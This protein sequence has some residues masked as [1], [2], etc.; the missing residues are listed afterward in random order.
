MRLIA[1]WFGMVMCLVTSCEG[2]SSGDSRVDTAPNLAQASRNYILKCS[3]CHG[4]DGAPVLL[5]APDLRTSTLDLDEREAIIA[6]GK[7]TMPPHQ[8]MLSKAEIRDLALYIEE[9]R[10]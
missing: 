9:F 7:G 8:A 4:A 2:G 3:V 1:L 10:H 5:T 6:Y